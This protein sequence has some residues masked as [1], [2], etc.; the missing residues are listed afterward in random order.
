MKKTRLSQAYGEGQ[1]AA[2]TKYAFVGVGVELLH[3]GRHGLN[4]GFPYGLG[5][6]YRLSD[7][8]GWAPQVGL[9]LLGPTLG[10]GYR[11]PGAAPALETPEQTSVD[12]GEN[13]LDS[14]ETL[15]PR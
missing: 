7:D 15:N 1:R 4:L 5:Y 13:Y 14:H 9:G 11:F 10:P 2:L 12:A 6:S 8:P 3:R